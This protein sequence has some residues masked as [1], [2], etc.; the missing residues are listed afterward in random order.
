MIGANPTF[1]CPRGAIL[2][3]RYRATLIFVP[4]T[5]IRILPLSLYILFPRCSA[6]LLCETYS[7]AAV[8]APITPASFLFL[9]FPA[10]VCFEKSTSYCQQAASSDALSPRASYM[11]IGC[12]RPSRNWDGDWF[13]GPVT[14]PDVLFRAQ[15]YIYCRIVCASSI[16]GGMCVLLLY[17]GRA[18]C[19]NN[20]SIILGDPSI[21]SVVCSAFFALHVIY[22]EVI[23]WLRQFRFLLWCWCTASAV[24]YN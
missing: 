18:V 17:F 15:R 20:A 23:E 6:F 9:F 24:K 16:L 5:R 8:H 19:T 10:V 2:A 1:R 13:V 14:S 4:L 3:E 12:L 22:G 7:V 21:E 11:L